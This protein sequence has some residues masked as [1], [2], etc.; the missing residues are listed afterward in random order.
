MNESENSRNIIGRI[1]FVLLWIGCVF[2]FLGFLC[3]LLFVKSGPPKHWSFA[4]M[5]TFIQPVY[6]LM[7]FGGNIIFSF[8]SFKTKDVWLMLCHTLFNE[9]IEIG[10]YKKDITIA[11]SFQKANIYLGIIIACISLMEINNYEVYSK[12]VQISAM[13]VRSL[14]SLIYIGG[15]NLCI[16][17]PIELKLKEKMKK[18]GGE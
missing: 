14:V 2:A 8:I 9:N 16:F 15:I 11:K 1:F 5:W 17:F 3:L 7:F 18:L 13:I 10:R 6:M 4:F 12:S